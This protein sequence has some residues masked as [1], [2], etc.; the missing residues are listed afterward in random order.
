MFCKSCGAEVKDASARFCEFCGS[1]VGDAGAAGATQS[2]SAASA[3]QA[4]GATPTQG[5]PV[6]QQ[7]QFQQPQQPGNSGGKGKRTGLIV[8][9]VVAVIVILGGIG[10]MAGGSGKASSSSSSTESSSVSSSSAASSSSASS[11]SS[12]SSAVSSSSSAGGYN[13]NAQGG[14][15]TIGNNK[16]G[17]LQVPSD[18]KDRTSDFDSNL[19]SDTA[20][21]YYVDPTSE[22]TSSALTKFNFAQAIQM[23]ALP[24]SYAQAAYDLAQNWEAQDIYADVDSEETT[25]NGHK[26][27]I[28]TSTIPEDGLYLCDIVIDRDDNGHS[29]VVI[30]TQ[31]TPSSM[32]AVLGY[33]A[34]WSN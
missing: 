27:T 19:V 23:R 25:F 21:V 32:E 13:P 11:S 28:I 5:Q 3:A 29:A 16:T 17:T 8:G 20:L 7:P 34:T 33:A 10:C 24:T 30:M 26:A 2:F 1:P 12:S 14:K 22:Y 4:L 15:Q 6:G 31:A 18:W 9:I